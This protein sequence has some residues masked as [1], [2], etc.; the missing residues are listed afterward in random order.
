MNAAYHRSLVCEELCE[1]LM[2]GNLVHKFD[3]FKT[4]EKD[5]KGVQHYKLTMKNG[6]VLVYSPKS[7]FIDGNKFTSLSSAKAYLQKTY[8][9]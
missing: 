9:F 4:K 3:E 8:V 7:I 1:T 6:Q 5:K 2:W